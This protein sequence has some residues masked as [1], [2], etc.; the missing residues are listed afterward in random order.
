MAHKTRINGT[1]YG[2]SGGKCR[3][4]GTNYS[5]KKG[6]TRVSGTG[7]DINFAPPTYI[8]FETRTSSGTTNIKDV[9]YGDG[10][11]VTLHL[12]A[13]YYATSLEGPWTKLSYPAGFT[14]STMTCI[15]Y[16]NG[17]WVIGGGT[18]S[19]ACI[20]Y[21]TS[22]TGTW[23]IKT[24][25]TI[26]SSTYGYV[27]SIE[28]GNGYWVAG[29]R[30]FNG[31][32]YNAKIAYCT[33]IS[34]NWITRDL[35]TYSTTQTSGNADIE[36]VRYAN[37]QWVVVGSDRN[38][39]TY[40]VAYT[41]SSAP[42]SWNV[43]NL[44]ISNTADS[45]PLNYVCD[46]IYANNQWVIGMYFDDTAGTGYNKSRI[47]YTTNPSSGWLYQDIVISEKW[48]SLKGIA[49]G[50]GYWV[51]A[52]NGY[53]SSTGNIAYIAYATSLTGTWTQKEIWAIPSA[54]DGASFSKFA[55]INNYFLVAGY[56]SRYISSK[57]NYTSR[58]QWS[59]APQDFEYV[60]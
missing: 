28:Y 48:D 5:I 35:W 8:D 53:N 59:L 30:H 24:L 4:S 16:A 37:N 42:T 44:F 15:I 12:G 58:L 45:S 34:G 11:W 52:V 17:Y 2:I 27:K 22:L 56:Y 38:Q 26:S 10:Y 49:Y 7:Y 23:T 6:R 46:I 14:M 39:H 54:V 3:V 51:I 29:G 47:Y 36:R 21:S 41:S 60:E 1:N 31:S 19:A 32:G 57:S 18:S 20:A 25:W 9:C 40:K 13:L 55:F 43:S 33:S 50:N